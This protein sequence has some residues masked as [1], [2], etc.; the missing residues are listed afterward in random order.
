LTVS[1]QIFRQE[2]MKNY[3]KIM[4]MS[5]LYLGFT[6]VLHGSEAIPNRGDWDAGMLGK[7]EAGNL[8]R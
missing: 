4:N 1:F 6:R 5:S 7:W 3:T 8:R 2:F